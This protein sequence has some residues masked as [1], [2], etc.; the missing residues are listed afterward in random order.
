MFYRQKGFYISLMAGIIAIIAFT[1]ICLNTI[2]N[3]Q[4]G[5]EE[6]P[7]EDNLLA[8]ASMEPVEIPDIPVEPEAEAVVKDIPAESKK[9]KTKPTV[10]P[11]TETASQPNKPP[12][13]HFDQEKGLLWPITGNVL[14]TYSP[15]KVIYFKTLAQYRTNSAMVIES[16]VDAKVKASADGIVKSVST[17]EEL[18]TILTMSIG[19][20][21]TVS[22]G[23]LKDVKLKKGDSVKEGEVVGKVAQPTKYYSVEGPNL[24]YQVKSGKDTVNPMVLLR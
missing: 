13:M 20:D 24:Y 12:A 23:Q 18:G 15:D 19:D 6:P 2:G 17:S 22:Y 7:I 4:G 10:K 5:D 3:N 14:L 21:F 9:P 8:S 16:E 11:R 1:A